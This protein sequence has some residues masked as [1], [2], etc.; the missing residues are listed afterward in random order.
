MKPKCSI[1]NVMIKT[2][3]HLYSQTHSLMAA[4]VIVSLKQGLIEIGTLVHLLY[5]NEEIQFLNMKLN[6]LVLGHMSNLKVKLQQ[7]LFEVITKT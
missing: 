2:T 6:Q 1:Y 3:V 5:L 7:L 4:V